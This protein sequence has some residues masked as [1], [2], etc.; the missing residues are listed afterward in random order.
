MSAILEKSLRLNN[1]VCE[2]WRDSGR[3]YTI[4]RDANSSEY[5]V[6][7]PGGRMVRAC[8]SKKR[9]SPETIGMLIYAAFVVMMIVTMMLDYAG[10]L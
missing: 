2:I 10:A 1:K 4:F 7:C 8:A 3:S 9:H 5:R 6:Y